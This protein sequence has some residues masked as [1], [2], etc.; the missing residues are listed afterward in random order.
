VNGHETVDRIWVDN[1]EFTRQNTDKRTTLDLAFTALT[2]GG[3]T[4]NDAHQF[5]FGVVLGWASHD[6]ERTRNGG[7]TIRD[8]YDSSDW[9]DEIYLYSRQR[10]YNFYLQDSWTIGRLTINPGLRFTVYN[11][12]FKN[13][14]KDIYDTSVF[15]PRLGVAYDVFGDGSTVVKGH[16]GRYDQGLFAWM[17]DR[18]KS[19]HAF[20]PTYYYDYN[21]DTG[22]Y[23]IPAGGLP[24]TL[25]T[26]DPGIDQPYVDQ[27][28]F[29]AERMLPMDFTVGVDVIY[30]RFRDIIAMVNL[31]ADYD[32]LRAPDNPLT[33]GNL[34]FYELLSDQD[35]HLVNPGGAYRNYSSVALRV[36]KRFSDNWSLRYSLVWSELAGN[37]DATDGYAPEWEDKNG[38][39]NFVGKLPGFHPWESKLN[40][41]YYFPWDIFATAYYT[42]LTGEYWTPYV[43]IDGLWYNDRSDALMESRGSNRYPSQHQVDLKVSKTFKFQDRYGLEFTLDVFN[44][45]DKRAATSVDEQWGWYEY[46]YTDHPDSSYWDPNPDFGATIST[47]RPRELRL[48]VKFS[49]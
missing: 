26:L 36:N 10:E 14:A 48:G 18:E 25:A 19:G 5:R 31:N 45:L 37:T 29:G 49:F 40:V 17:Y 24:A 8:R 27:F 2:S 15:A 7:Y 28:V 22:E 20:T 33:G 9:G 41:T 38:Q 13:T 6:E 4:E 44:L 47:M 34:M 21:P 43:Q 30:R 42:Y 39:T 16:M 46:D 32:A 3:F 35:Y 1:N 12:G 11:G 23:D